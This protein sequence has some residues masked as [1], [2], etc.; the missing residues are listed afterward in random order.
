MPCY[1]PLNGYV[2]RK[3]NESGKRSIVFN[4][5]D[6]YLDLPVQL[7][8]GQCIGC[9]L[10]RS[11]QWAMRCVHEASLY[12]DNC[13]ITLTFDD[14]HIAE[15]KSLCKR[16]FQLFMKRLRKKFNTKIRYYHCGEYGENFGRPHHHACIFG[17]D[18]PD[19]EWLSRKDG[20]D[21]YTSE[22]LSELWGHGYCTIGS[23]TFESAAYVARYIM[24]KITGEKAE[25]YYGGRLPEYTTMSRRP[26]LGKDWF[27]QFKSD[28][29]PHDRVIMRGNI[30]CRPP[31]YYDALYDLDNHE[32][33]SILKGKRER[34]AKN[35]P[36]M[37]GERL[38]VKMKV[39]Q[40]AIAQLKRGVA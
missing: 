35:N 16:D 27:K 15:D 1:S 8:C 37:K 18:F 5:R 21:L 12:E 34:R 7:P 9:R 30:Q 2:A 39:K 29:Y 40:A 13:F 11:R 19:K 25:E 23:V 17:F 4:H 31:K 6:G 10:E 33:M 24:K 26:G 38:L 20:V 36:N 3:P 22:I 28:V 32:I 14:Q